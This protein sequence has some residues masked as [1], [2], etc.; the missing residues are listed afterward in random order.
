MFRREFCQAE[1]QHFRL[2]FVVD[3]DVR[4][5]DVAVNDAVRVCFRQSVGD[6]QGKVEN[7]MRTHLLAFEP[8]RER[9]AFDVLHHD[10]SAIIVSAIS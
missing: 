2:S 5:F 8:F 4:R 7:F 1:V 10:K 6:L 9:F 3:D